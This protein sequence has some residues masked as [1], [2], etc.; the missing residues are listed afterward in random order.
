MST[1]ELW[2]PLIAEYG[3][4]IMV[5]FYL[6]HRLEQKLDKVAIAVEQLPEKLSEIK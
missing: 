6:L 1:F 2:V 4:P 3:F 5:T